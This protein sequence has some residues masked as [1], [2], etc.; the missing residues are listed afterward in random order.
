MLGT[1][2]TIARNSKTRFLYLGWGNC[3]AA[4]FASEVANDYVEAVQ[5]NL[6]DYGA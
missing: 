3:K 2:L 4:T 6:D 5:R 1:I